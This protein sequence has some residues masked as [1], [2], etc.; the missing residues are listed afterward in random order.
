LKQTDIAI[1]RS[2]ANEP[3]RESERVQ[4][5]ERRVSPDLVQNESTRSVRDA[6]G[7]WQTTETRNKESRTLSPAERVD[8]ETVRR[9]D[10]NGTLALSERTLTRQS[11]G[12]GREETVIETYSQNAPGTNR[13]SSSQLELN[14][15]VR[16]TSTSSADGR[17]TIREVEARNQASTNAAL[18]V[19]ERTVETLRRVG[20]D[21]WEI[22]RQTFALDANGRLVPVFTEKGEAAGK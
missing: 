11:T 13:S 20:P 22:E 12:S 2:G 19:V 21:R 15:R 1:Y 17:Q 10:V 18:R 7:R 3:L 5:T 14:G 6:N 4:Q 9:V 16:T 8:E